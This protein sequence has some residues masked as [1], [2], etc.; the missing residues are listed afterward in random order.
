MGFSSVN[1]TLL[2]ADLEYTHVIEL[3]RG[4]LSAVGVTMHGNAFDV[5]DFRAIVTLASQPY[6]AENAIVPLCQGLVGRRSWLSWT[7]RIK[8]PP[9]TGLVLL[10]HGYTTTGARFS[11]VVEET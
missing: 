1:F 7:G 9:N 6:G 4:Y 2:D 11:C 10:A 8:I 3:T 5:L